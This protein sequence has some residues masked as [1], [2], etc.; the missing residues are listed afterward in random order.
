MQILKNCRVNSGP[1]WTGLAAALFLGT[2][3]AGCGG[4]TG[5]S[6]R[7]P[8]PV[9]D[10]AGSLDPRQL[11]A[12]V[13]TQVTEDDFDE[14][15]DLG[16]ELDARGDALFVRGV[17]DSDSYGQVYDVLNGELR[18]GTLVFTMVP[19]SA[20]DDTNLELGRA[21][22]RAGIVTYLPARGTIASGG[23]DLFL[24]GVRRVVESGA[25]VGVHSWSTDDS[26]APT[27]LSLP[28]DHPEH[29]KYL[30]YYRYMGIPEDF[31]WFTLQAAPPEGMHW[32]TEEEMAK[33]RIYTDL[34]R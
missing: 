31:Y 16:L 30:N 21:L 2:M 13:D 20:D 33:Y 7:D 34:I 29:E 4:D 26:H 6:I 3:L 32:M 17:V 25:L 22:R 28:R 10:I 11:G 14:P 18:I 5:P 12:W 23:T 19:G 24:S 9:R 1:A 8:L 27:A 15:F